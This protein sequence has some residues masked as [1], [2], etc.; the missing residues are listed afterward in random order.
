MIGEALALFSAFAF[1]LGSVAIAKA[2]TRGSGESGVLLAVLITGILSAIA[3]G[4]VS[5]SAATSAAMQPASLAWFAASGVLATVW[6]RLAL[7]KSI[8]H[9]G[10]IRASG[11]RAAAS[12]RTL[13]RGP[14]G[15]S[16]WA[17]CSAWWARHPMH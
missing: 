15:M 6:G 3:W 12:K 1:A 4:V 2:M 10:V 8:H 14:T 11:T 7:F 5:S 17:T 9:A 16:V 13:L